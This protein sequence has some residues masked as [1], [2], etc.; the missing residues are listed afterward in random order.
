GVLGL[1]AG[2][3]LLVLALLGLLDGALAGI[4]A[5]FGAGAFLSALTY[6]AM[7][8]GSHLHAVVLAGAATALVAAG[9]SASRGG[10][11]L[12]LGIGAVLGATILVVGL[13][14]LGSLRQPLGSPKVV[15]EDAAVA[16]VRRLRGHRWTG[17]HAPLVRAVGLGV[18]I[19]A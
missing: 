6:G 11:Q 12:S 5:T 1:A 3:V 8:T 18:V 13:V 19:L 15:V 9:V 2:G 7:R 17:R 16:L 4:A 10:W 14:V